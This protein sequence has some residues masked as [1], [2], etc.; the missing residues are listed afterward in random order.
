MKPRTSTFYYLLSKPNPLHMSVLRVAD[1]PEEIGVAWRA[2][3][4]KAIIRKSRMYFREGDSQTRYHFF[5]LDPSEA[6]RTG[7]HIDE[8][9]TLE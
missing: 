2:L 4:S 8:W 3:K 7:I 5:E 6:L 1:S 9:C